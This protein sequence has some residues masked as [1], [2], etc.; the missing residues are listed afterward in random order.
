MAQITTIEQLRA[1]L[2]EPNPLTKSKVRDALDDQA[3]G[4][5][6]ASPFLL[7]ATKNADGSLEISPK[8][9]QPGFVAV[10]DDRTL[11]LPD[12]L[13]NNLAFGLTNILGDPE[14]GLIFLSPGTGET[15][16]VGGRATIHDDAPLCE[17]LAARGAAAKLVIRVAVTRAYFH[18]ARAALRAGLWRPDGWPEAMRISFGRIIAEATGGAADLAAQIDGRVAEGYRSGL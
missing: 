18:C 6:A 3:R 9:D 10:E 11:L 13:G 7:L 15:L 12:R 2:A 5:I 1:K 14:V 8:G 16:R 17:R 4:F